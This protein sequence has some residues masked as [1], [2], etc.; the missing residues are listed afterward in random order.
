MEKILGKCRE[1]TKI[2]TAIFL[3]VLCIYYTI[4]NISQ[5]Y[6]SSP[7]EYMKYDLCKY[8]FENNSLPHGGDEAIRDSNWGISYAFEPYLS[9]IISAGFMKI[10]SIFT[11]DEFALVIAARF[12]STLFMIGFIYVLI[13]ISQILF[14]NKY[15]YLF[16]VF[17]AFQP[18][19]AFLAS[20]INNDSM[21]LFSISIIVYSWIL[22]L[23][24]NW[25]DK[26]CILLGL[27]IGLC[28]LSYYNAYGYILCS[29]VLC[30]V[31][32]ILNKMHI[33]DIIK[34]VL[35]VFTIAF[36]IAGWWFIRNA[37]I[38]NGDVLGMS[39]QTEYAQKYAIDE[40]KPS[41]RLTPQQKDEGILEMLFKDKWI[42]LT[43]K[44]F[45][46]VFGYM[47]IQMPNII[48]VVIFS[49]WAI[50]IIGC[51]LGLNE[52]F[53]CGNKEKII[54]NYTFILAIIIVI[55]LSLIYSYSSDFQPQGRYIMPIIIPFMYFIS[56]GIEKILEKCIK[57]EK[58]KNIIFMFLIIFL[59]GTS[60]FALFGCVIPYYG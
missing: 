35:I 25:Q 45:Y 39:T 11:A 60:I 2:L 8:I 43:F 57:N 51:I 40:L 7:D 58:I 30:L 47:T 1:N 15:K 19:T 55:I 42:R 56:K 52:L 24:H 29:V 44:S 46:G 18:I 31:S 3:L 36:V 22:G 33:K 28:L 27:G 59:V 14:E 12:V 32:V 17:I 16:I 34:K 21:A 13:K 4:W 6:N 9:Y 54:L 50:G 37:I 26:Y 49:I 5:P 23:E 41:N 38:Y 20:Y 48:Y 53:K 10:M